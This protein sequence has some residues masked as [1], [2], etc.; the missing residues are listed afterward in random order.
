MVMELF[1]KILP[2]PYVYEWDRKL[3][4]ANI[5][6][7]GEFITGSLVLLAFLSLIMGFI[8]A[9]NDVGEVFRKLGI[10]DITIQFNEDRFVITRDTI[11]IFSGTLIYGVLL[12]ILFYLIISGYVDLK[13]DIVRRESERVLP[14]FLMNLAASIRSGNIIDQ[15]MLDAAKEEYGYFSKLVRARVK[16][17]YSGVPIDQ[18]ILKLSED[19]DSVVVR[20]SF[21]IIVEGIKTG[22]RL[23]DIIEKLA[24]D[25]REIQNYKDEIST[26]LTTYRSFIFIASVFGMP[27]LYAI[28][29]KL[30]EVLYRTFAQIGDMNIS[31]G[32]LPLNIQLSVPSISKDAF[33]YFAV[34]SIFITS[35]FTS[36]IIS[37]SESRKSEFYKNLVVTLVIGYLLLYIFINLIDSLFGGLNI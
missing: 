5:S 14:E 10:K 34:L 16:E 31:P 30:I 11:I 17:Y 7:S 13:G 9:S 33:L 3:K 21:I 25:I 35:L 29:L 26:S 15:A 6:L 18:A 37:N 20:R 2:R 24:L 19:F 36:K 4:Y 28:S 22:A 8:L 32:L 23:A 1:S 12:Y 27:L